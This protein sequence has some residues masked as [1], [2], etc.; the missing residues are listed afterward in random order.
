MKEYFI[1]YKI[2]NVEK[3]IFYERDIKETVDV[4]EGNIKNKIMSSLGYGY[5]FDMID[6]I[7]IS[8]I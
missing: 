2:R 1:R 7:F 6:I 8:Q 3:N 5:N 4:F